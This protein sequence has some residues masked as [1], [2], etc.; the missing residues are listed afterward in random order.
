MN[1]PEATFLALVA[2]EGAHSIEEYI[3]RLWEVFPPARY[4]TGLVSQ[5][6][7]FGFVVINVSLFLFGVWCVLWPV[8]HRWP[9]V[10]VFAGIWIGIATLNGIGHPLWSLRLQAYTPGVITA[11]VLLILAIL[12]AV[13]L[14]KLGTPSK[15]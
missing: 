9:S 2:V 12:L 8:R 11:P 1:R 5:D 4:I 15:S 10:R 14:G 7:Q 6:H 13:Q 3:G